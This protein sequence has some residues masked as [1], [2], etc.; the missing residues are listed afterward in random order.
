M[1]LK[2]YDYQKEGVKFLLTHKHALLCFE[3]G[4]G[5]TPT[6]L[7]A[8]SAIHN[9]PPITIICPAI[10][11]E[12][13]K[14]E[15]EKWKITLPHFI[16]S[17]N[18]L[19]LAPQVKG[20]TLILD[21]A[22]YI[23]SPKAKRTQNILSHPDGLVHHASRAWCLTGTP[24]PNHA[25]ELWPIL[26]TF[27][28][29][30]LSYNAFLQEYCTGYNHAF[31]N[32]R[33][34]TFVVTGTN[35]AKI[36]ELKTLLEPVM[37]YKSQE[38]AKVQLPPLSF[39]SHFIKADSAEITKLDGATRRKLYEEVKPLMAMVIEN[40]G[41][42]NDETL[43]DF[44]KGHAQSLTTLRRIL[45]L[46]K[47][48]KTAELIGEDLTNKNYLKAVV[49]Y[50]HKQVKDGLIHEFDKRGFLFGQNVF[51]IEGGQTH[52]TRWQLIDGFNKTKE[53]SVMLA[54]ITAASTAISLNSANQVIFIEQS[55]VPG[56]NAQAVK[57]CHR[58]GQK[59]PVFSRTITL[60][61]DPVDEAISQTILRKTQEITMLL[62]NNN[63]EEKINERTD[64]N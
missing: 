40:G 31:G 47:V 7:V 32:S 23:K 8:A 24:M 48:V 53:P 3:M 45:G 44:I 11:V 9:P 52:T 35:R 26:T 6:A 34:P 22:H 15:I 38:E 20:H 4:L 10:A 36:P 18:K 63:R 54:Q 42:F 28:R 5:K 59:L 61:D 29:T 27:N 37:L 60:L 41:A 39:S 51:T 46:Q 50:H 64:Y 43:L 30:K 14:R 19:P 21:E 57:R 25:G 12:N 16:Y 17:Y 58:H 1:T 55:W 2:L 49:F 33:H 56:E 13:W 62:I